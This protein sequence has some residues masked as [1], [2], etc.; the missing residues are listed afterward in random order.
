M[1]E[2]TRTSPSLVGVSQPAET[3]VPSGQVHGPGELQAPH[4][5]AAPDSA[6]SGDG[7][8]LAPALQPSAPT[9]ELRLTPEQAERRIQ[10][11]RPDVLERAAVG[12]IRPDGV[13]LDGWGTKVLARWDPASDTFDYPP[14]QLPGLGEVQ[15]V[16]DNGF[17]QG[18]EGVGVLDFATMQPRW[19]RTDTV[20]WRHEGLRQDAH[21]LSMHSLETGEAIWSLGPEDGLPTD[22]L[23]PSRSDR[24]IY[25][26][27]GSSE[28]AVKIDFES[29]TLAWAVQFP[30]SLGRMDG[31]SPY[32]GDGV[33]QFERGLARVNPESGELMWARDDL[34]EPGSSFA[35]RDGL[36]GARHSTG[37]SQID[38][39]TGRTLWTNPDAGAHIDFELSA[40][41][42]SDGTRFIGGPVAATEGRERLSVAIL[43]PANGAVLFETADLAPLR[44]RFST[45]GIERT[46]RFYGRE[47]AEHALEQR[48]RFDA[49]DYS[50]FAEPVTVLMLPERDENGVFQH[51]N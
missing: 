12:D 38:L 39:E 17:I 48:E 51:N 9:R 23:F 35:Y 37:L 26:T 30:E 14:Q 29:G 31:N 7:D 27:M 6:L 16:W 43:D 3:P 8:A 34:G 24:S 49:G 20:R 4:E 50:M 25:T 47:F 15:T 33:F 13:V 21:S 40:V 36:L 28:G 2:I 10:A 46:E 22:H 45:V 44:D 1:T 5:H 11:E 19:T 41:R 32:H 18:A 42:G